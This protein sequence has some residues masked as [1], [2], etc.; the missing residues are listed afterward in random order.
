MPVRKGRH[1]RGLMLLSFYLLWAPTVTAQVS[2]SLRAATE[3]VGL[4]S[5]VRVTTY[6][7]V[8]MSGSFL[9]LEEHQ[10]RLL[11]AD[12]HMRALKAVGSDDTGEGQTT[13]ESLGT[14]AFDLVRFLAGVP[15]LSRT[16]HG[17][18]GYWVT[19]SPSLRCE[20]RHGTCQRQWDTLR[21]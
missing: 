3:G 11:R 15:D 13:H 8:L 4:G 12:Q 2:P 21:D 20:R 6:D 10:Q 5:H 7:N 18:T 1:N 16:Y 9:G 19:W 17:E 14:V